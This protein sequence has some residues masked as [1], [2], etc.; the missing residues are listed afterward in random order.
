MS[1]RTHE[2]FAASGLTA[3]EATRLR[4][5]LD[6]DGRL[7]QWPARRAIQLAAL[8]W[9]A[10]HFAVSRR[11]TQQEIDATIQDLHSFADWVFLRRELIDA[12]LL[13]R[14]DDGRAYWK[15]PPAPP[16]EH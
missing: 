5:F 12:R 10:T 7:K 4:R 3:E 8:R 9:L 13:D 6:E 11:Y 15:V 16:S 14:T 1:D 2:A